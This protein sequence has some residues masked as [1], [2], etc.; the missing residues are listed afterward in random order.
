M[1]LNLPT[2][3]IIIQRDRADLKGAVPEL[4]PTIFESLTFGIVEANAGRHF[5][6]V[7]SIAQLEKEL[8][9]DTAELESL[10]RWAVYDGIIPFSAEQSA[11][12]AVFTGVLGTVIPKDRIFRNAVGDTYISQAAIAIVNSV[13][14]ITSL[15]RSGTTVTAVCSSNH[16]LATNI[17][18]TI[19]GAVETDYNGAYAIVVL[20]KTSF[21][22]EIT[23]TPTT[24]AT[25][26]I[27]VSCLCARVDVNSEETG[28]DK[29]LDSGATLT[30]VTP[31]T[32]V[33]DDG[34]F[35]FDGATGGRDAETKASLLN[36][37]KSRRANPVAN[38]NVGAISKQMFLISGVTRIKVK[39]VTPG[40]GQVTTLFVKDGKSN[41]IPNAGEVAEVK[42]S[43]VEILQ[44]TSEESDVIVT[45]PTP[46]STNYVFSSITPD[47]PTMQDAIAK[48]L[49]AFYEDE[50][51][52][53]I[54]ITEDKY[55]SIIID[56]IDLDTG[57]RLSS[58]SLSSPSGDI[59]I[60]TDS[61]GV[62]GSVTF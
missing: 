48:N 50:A 17:I 22:Y 55:K 21:S 30:F 31:L 43:I 47:S 6:N 15:V 59:A 45:A 34:Y 27:T 53:E 35:D 5:D 7:Q 32:D 41:I 62:I 11:G 39:R 44:A 56:S 12:T 19:A 38:F 40:I 3:N 60:G 29:N 33:D 20:S 37:V 8:F 23:G 36:R 24:P 52:F 54:A 14:N 42:A 2:Y 51:T 13:I 57:E 1:P 16:N 49:A 10:K 61:I 25:G 4:D 18:A 9:P 28:D 26:T 46:V 58:F